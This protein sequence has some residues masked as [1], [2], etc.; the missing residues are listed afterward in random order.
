MRRLHPLLQAQLRELRARTT[1]S[2][3]GAH[4]LLEML[5][6]YYDTSMTSAARWCARCSSCRTRRARSA[7]KCAEQGAAQL[8]VILDHIKDVVIT[9]DAEGVI[10]RANP[11]TERVFAYPP[12]EL[13]GLRIDALVPESRVDGSIAAG[14]RPARRFQ[15]HVPR[16]CAQPRG[17][18]A[19]L[20]R[21]AVPGRDRGQPRAHWAPRSFRDLP[22]RHLRAAQSTRKRCATAKRATARWSTTRP[23]R[24][25]S[26]MPTPRG[27]SKP[28]NRR[29]ACSSSTREQLLACSLGD[30]SAEM[31]PD[32]TAV[33]VAAPQFLQARARPANPQ[34]FEWIH[35]DSTGREI[36]CEAAPRAARRRFRGAGARQH[37]RHLGAQA[38]RDH[39]ARTS[40]RSSRCSL[41][42]AQ[43]AGGAR[44]HLRAGA[45]RVPALPLHDLR[46]RARREL[47]R[48]DDRAPAAADAGR[49]ARTHTHRTAPRLLRRG[50]VF[51]LRRVR[52]RRGQRRALGRSPPGGARL[53][54]PRRLVHAHQGRER[55]A[56]GLGGYLPPGAWPAGFARAGAAIACRAPRGA[57]HRAQ[58]RRGGAAH[59]RGEIPRPV[60]GRHRGCLPEHARRPAGVG[61]QCVREDAGLQLGRRD[62]RAAEL[63]DAVLERA[64]PRRV[65]AQGRRRRR[66]PLHGSRAAP[67]RRHAG[68]GPGELARR[69]RR[70]GP[71]RRLRRHGLRHHRAQARR[72]GDVRRKGPRAG[73]AAV[74]RRRRDQHRRRT[75]TSTT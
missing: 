20:G 37:H 64:R 47:L 50:R 7:S 51:G 45:G 48:A 19:A 54:V 65:R 10:D 15:R 2:R 22:A 74:D 5:S 4:E 71:H 23:R 55:Q 8:Q 24:S 56:A 75:R 14:L 39:H 73:H 3:M 30:V 32:G 9:V 36:P 34:V 46:A 52:V 61:E 68:R 59:Q 27:S 53:R 69:S 49:R 28:T 43:P 12:G 40:A 66:G 25:P 13:P 72:A 18:R 17:H 67:A 60:R 21:H 31:Q 57:R 44:R 1:G 63:R 26:S 41:S 11:M 70:L 35:R 62:V 16:P 29:C 58:P 42:N 38:R 33:D 6:R